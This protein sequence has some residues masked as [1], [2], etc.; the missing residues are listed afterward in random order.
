MEE[1]FCG[2]FSQHV[3]T[4]D[5]LLFCGVEKRDKGH[6]FSEAHGRRK[7]RGEEREGFSVLEEAKGGK[8]GVDGKTTKQR[9]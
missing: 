1:F 8:K 4:F 9:D 2:G 5:R 6:W 7:R 3:R